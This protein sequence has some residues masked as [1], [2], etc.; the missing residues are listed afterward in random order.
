MNRILL[1]AM[2]I[3]PLKSVKAEPVNYN[4]GFCVLAG[5]E[6]VRENAR[7]IV[8]DAY[9]NGTFILDANHQFFHPAS[10]TQKLE[11]SN[12]GGNH[13]LAK[14]SVNPDG[15]ILATYEN[16]MHGFDV[17][18]AQVICKVDEPPPKVCQSRAVLVYD[19]CFEMQANL[20]VDLQKQ[21]FSY[22]QNFHR[23]CP[24]WTPYYP[25]VIGKV[26]IGYGRI[27]LIENGGKKFGSLDYR[28]WSGTYAGT[29][30]GARFEACQFD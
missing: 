1:I 11:T 6:V 19:G 17:K 27:E 2:L 29:I 5:Q 22:R 30:D 26:Q 20:T 28:L 18:R 24:R 14:Q 10:E 16:H 7:V 12:W 23:L 25:E 4:R 21:T 9:L 3:A 8:K 15:T 13:T